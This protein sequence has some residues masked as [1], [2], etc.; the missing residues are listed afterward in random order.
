MRTGLPTTFGSL[1]EGRKYCL[2]IPGVLGGEYDG[3]N[4]AT[5]SL[6]V[7][8]RFSGDVAKKIRDLPDGAKIELKITD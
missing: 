8:V 4:L 7:L 2:K 6:V 3:A 1:S 5:I